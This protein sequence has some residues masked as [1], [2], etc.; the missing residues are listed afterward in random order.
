MSSPLEKFVLENREKFD[1]ENPDPRVWEKINEK[2]NPDSEKSA[3][4]ISMPFKRWLAAAAA[5]VLLGLPQ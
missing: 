4:V 1:A 5:I 3:P 2:L